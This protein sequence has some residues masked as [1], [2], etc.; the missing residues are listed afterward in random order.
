MDPTVDKITTQK[1]AST[2]KTCK[3]T[4]HKNKSTETRQAQTALSQCVL[5][6]GLGRAFYMSL[7]RDT[8]FLNP[9]TQSADKTSVDFFHCD[10]TSFT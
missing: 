4:D 8:L 1:H 2:I 6:T 7:T 9:S 10:I 3:V 5:C